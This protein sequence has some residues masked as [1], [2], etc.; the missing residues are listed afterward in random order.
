M[1][2]NISYG[3]SE[4]FNP[5]SSRARI[6]LKTTQVSIYFI[7]PHTIFFMRRENPAGRQYLKFDSDRVAQSS[8]KWYLYD[9]HSLLSPYLQLHSQ[10]YVFYEFTYFQPT[11]SI[12]HH[13]V[14]QIHHNQ[15]GFRQNAAQIQEECEPS[16]VAP[17]YYF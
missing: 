6:S 14:H 8:S 3:F 1:N 10:H 7:P 9:L 4:I 15:E 5:Q 2:P 17:L 16:D 11:S 12:Y 13:H